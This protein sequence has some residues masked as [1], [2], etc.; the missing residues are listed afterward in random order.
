MSCNPVTNTG[1]VSPNECLLLSSGTTTCAVAGYGTQGSSCSASVLCAGG[2]GCF[3]TCRKI[4]LKST[5]AGCGA[6]S[7]CNSV[8]GWTTYGACT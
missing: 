8:T 5:G 1:C 7:V 6:G 3:G 2:Y 4:C